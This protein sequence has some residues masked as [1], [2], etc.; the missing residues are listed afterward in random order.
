M[1][2][3]LLILPFLVLGTIPAF[4]VTVTSE[5]LDDVSLLKIENDGIAEIHAV[6]M[7]LDDDLK[8]KSFTAESGWQGQITP[9]GIMIFAAD[10]PLYQDES[11]K[12]GI[13][14]DEI[15]PQINYEILDIDGDV[16]EQGIHAVG[17]TTSDVDS[18]PP[19]E[20]VV[21]DFGIKEGISTISLVP[22]TLYPGSTFR[23][24]GDAFSADNELD[25]I[26]DGAKSGT[27]SIDTDTFVYTA[28]VPQD[29]KDSISVTIDDGQLRIEETFDV[30]EPIVIPPIANDTV[31]T[32][33]K[34]LSIISATHDS[35]SKRLKVSGEYSADRS[36]IFKIF[37]DADE[38]LSTGPIST[39]EFGN[40]YYDEPLPFSVAG[41][42]EFIVGVNNNMINHTFV[43]DA[44]PMLDS[45]QLFLFSEKNHFE[46]SETPIFQIRGDPSLKYKYNLFSDTESEGD[47]GI[48][49]EG[50]IEMTQA[51]FTEI[52]FEDVRFRQGVYSLHVDNGFNEEILFFGISL[53]RTEVEFVITPSS[54]T[55]DA[56]KP[57]NL[58][59]NCVKAPDAT[60]PCD[61]PMNALF[62]INVYN[63][64]NTAVLSE[65]FLADKA[66]DLIP[67]QLHHDLIPGNYTLHAQSGS[68]FSEARFL[69]N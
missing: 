3:L 34:D 31:K 20:I 55:L 57:I 56:D 13:K 61:R 69:L 21:P 35:E 23:I 64:N 52:E 17:E 44:Q 36:L 59:L 50:T 24:L 6:K 33:E 25:I 49:S 29:A 11:A 19:K 5:S 42:V 16:I 8:F 4:A 18:I 26:I 62:A 66:G 43:M 7:W 51:G 53:D 27:I 1:N 46:S 14:T 48:I 68:K 67:K 47:K 58:V 30:R 32:I 10:E 41:Q 63:I 39:N 28:S 60:V 2:A 65:S 54:E 37:N 12:F 15:G 40:W 38:L 22:S 9:T 45:N